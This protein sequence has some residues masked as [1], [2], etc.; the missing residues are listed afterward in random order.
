MTTY[1]V[2]SFL[3]IFSITIALS[4]CSKDYGN[5]NSPT[6]EQFLQNASRNELNNL[7]SGTESGLKKQHVILP[8]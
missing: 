5:L 7:V 4:S 8:G 6:I 3:L 2:L 1:K